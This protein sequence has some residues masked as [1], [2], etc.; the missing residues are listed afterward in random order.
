MKHRRQ[1]ITPPAVLEKSVMEA[2]TFSASLQTPPIDQDGCGTVARM[3][4]R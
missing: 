2:L 4:G 3:D 1:R